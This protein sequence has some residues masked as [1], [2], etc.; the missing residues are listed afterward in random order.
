MSLS[1][2]SAVSVL[3]TTF[4]DGPLLGEALASV[5]GQSIDPLEVLVIDDGSDPATAPVVIEAVRSEYGLDVAYSWQENQGPS[6]A[7][8]AGIAKARGEFIAF[9]D[10]DDRWLPN[11]LELKLARISSLDPR[12]STVFDAFVE[13]DGESG[14]QLKTIPCGDFD[15]S[16]SESALGLPGGVP[17]GLPFQ[18]HR[19]DALR[20]VGGLDASLRVNED[21]DLLLRM[22]KAGYRMAG[23]G[24]VTVERRVHPASLT[25]KDPE[26]TF[27]EVTRFLDKAEREALMPPERIASR[28]MWERLHLARAM[29]RDSDHTVGAA[30]EQF[31]QA[32][33]HASPSG[34]RQWAAYILGHSGLLGIAIIK[35]YRMVTRGSSAPGRTNA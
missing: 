3:I 6:A 17:A 18:L 19:T 22:G 29:L 23:S 20:A 10:A 4:N 14:A 16:I 9:L 24:T 15:G 25:R 27:E 30:L 5:A 32:F 31:R 2:G 12:Y 28:R 26:Q 11:H 34:G 21:F 13:F 7:R 1:P 33:R 8:N 35:G